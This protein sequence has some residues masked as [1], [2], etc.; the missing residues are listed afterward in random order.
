MT[1]TVRWKTVSAVHGRGHCEAP[2]P[3]NMS[4]AGMCVVLM[5]VGWVCWWCV[6][7]RALCVKVGRGMERDRV[8]HCA[9]E[10]LR[11][12]FCLL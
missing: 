3:I 9:V 6:L 1:R 11:G 4:L 10:R 2:S 7:L 12:F 8:I 5:S